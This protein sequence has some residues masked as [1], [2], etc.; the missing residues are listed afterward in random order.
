[1]VCKKCKGSGYEGGEMAETPSGG[2][3]GVC[4]MTCKGTGEEYASEDSKTE[5]RQGA[6]K[7][8]RRRK[9]KSDNSSES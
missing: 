6:R 9:G 8:T 5:E 3:I 4:C 2:R 7:H 1:M